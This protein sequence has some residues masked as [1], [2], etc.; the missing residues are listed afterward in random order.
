MGD[1]A[2]VDEVVVVVGATVGSLDSSVVVVDD[3]AAVDDGVELES[4]V[5]APLSC[6]GSMEMV[7]A[8]SGDK[9]NVG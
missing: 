9:V 6:W 4:A 3:D 7:A 5:G 1:G 2:G 8:A